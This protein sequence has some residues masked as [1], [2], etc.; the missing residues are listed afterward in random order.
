M[1]IACPSCSTSFSVDGANIGTDGRAVRCFNCSHS[2][3]QYPVVHQP[4]A[5]FIPVQYVPPGQFAMPPQVAAPA[6]PAPA[7][8]FT[9]PP[10]P[11]PDPV[12]E[13]IFEPE[14]IPE[15]EPI[16]EPEPIE[17][18]LPSDEELDAMLGSGD[19]AEE[20]AF[21]Q[22]EIAEPEEIDIEDLDELDDPEPVEAFAP[23]V[24]NEFDDEDLDPEDIPDPDPIGEALYDPDDADLEDEAKGGIVMMLVKVLI[25]LVI[26]GGLGTGAIF[27]RGIVVDLIPA[28]NVVFEL[29]GMRVAIPG[30]GLKIQSGNPTREE[31]DGKEVIVIKGSVTNISDIEQRVPEVIIQAIDAENQV[32]QIQTLRLKNLTL[33]AGKSEKFS[34]VFKELVATARKLVVIYGPF[35]DDAAPEADAT[36]DGAAKKDDH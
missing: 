8:Q 7:P 21:D 6:A 2:W 36:K 34:A 1:Y 30:D 28:T 31:R 27:M 14:P 5:H 9:P 10:P 11:E 35:V 33:G 26:L 18:D 22:E 17:E 12:P 19:E 24:E 4:Q 25:V 29:L 16:P 20:S 3:H 15:Q 13:P 32:V 23:E